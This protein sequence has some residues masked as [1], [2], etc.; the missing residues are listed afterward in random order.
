MKLIFTLAF[1]AAAVCVP[2]YFAVTLF[3][4]GEQYVATT[5]SAAKALNN[6]R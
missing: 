1:W 2:T 5:T 3:S 4:A 6:N